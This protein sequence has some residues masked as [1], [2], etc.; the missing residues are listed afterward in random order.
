[1]SDSSGVRVLQAPGIS[2]S[3]GLDGSLGAVLIA[4][5]L[6][7]SCVRLFR[8]FIRGLIGTHLVFGE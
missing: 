8:R 2:T 4:T 3:S 5:L 7:M 1:M 6:S